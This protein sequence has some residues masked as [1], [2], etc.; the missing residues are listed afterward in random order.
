MLT[1]TLILLFVI[2]ILIALYFLFLIIFYGKNFDEELKD[3]ED[4]DDT[5]KFYHD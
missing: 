4:A 3:Y 2:L 1:N 5:E